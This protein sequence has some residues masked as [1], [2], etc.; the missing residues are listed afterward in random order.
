[1]ARIENFARCSNGH[2]IPY[3]AEFCPWCGERA[4]GS[5]GEASP[6]AVNDSPRTI[7]MEQTGGMETNTMVLNESCDAGSKIADSFGGM[8]THT[9][10]LNESPVAPERTVIM[11]PKDSKNSTSRIVAFLVTY[12]FSQEGTFYPL[13]EGRETIGR[14]SGA[15][16][17]VNDSKMSKE[18]AV[19]LYRNKKFIFED[20][21]STNG[22]LLNGK[23][24]IGQL[25]LHHGDI[26]EMGMAKYIFVEIPQNA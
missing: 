4:S 23:D 8:E 14:G 19:I 5:L 15:S 21:L 11:R 12:D 20:R 2:I 17:T 13:H 25:E 16:I 7:N 9:M 18:H 26:I 10:V 3:G 24:A 1:M 6:V 22:S